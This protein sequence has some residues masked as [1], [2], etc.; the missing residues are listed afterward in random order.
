MILEI[1]FCC[2][3]IIAFCTV[4]Y[5]GAV[6][7][8]QIVQK[9]WAPNIDW[10][11]LLSEQVPIVIRNVNPDWMGVWTRRSTEHKSWPTRVKQG[12]SLLQTTWREWLSSSPGQPLLENGDE[13]AKVV[14]IPLEEWRFGGFRRWAWLPFGHSIKVDVLGPSPESVRGVEKTRAT[15]TIL[16]STDGAP[17]Q[18]WLAHEAAM[19]SEVADELQ[20]RNPWILQSED[21][22]WIDEMKFIEIKLRPGNALALPA[23]WYYAVRT[24]LPVVGDHITMADGAWYWKATFQTP[25][26]WIA[27]IRT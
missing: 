1:I 5:K 13:M 10:S 17:L 24:Q 9:D 7:E 2:I 26:S 8:F 21:I 19:P 12:K 14:Q 6:H 18:V 11:S 15:T 16:Q 20:G 23:H 4:S 27:S 22:P 3:V 25:I